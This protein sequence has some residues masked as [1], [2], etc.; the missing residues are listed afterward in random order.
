MNPLSSSRPKTASARSA[1]PDSFIASI[2]RFTSPV[3]SKVPNSIK[4]SDAP[5]GKVNGPKFWTGGPRSEY[6][7]HTEAVVWAW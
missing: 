1:P 2:R 4:P 6:G 3:E 5:D 7:T